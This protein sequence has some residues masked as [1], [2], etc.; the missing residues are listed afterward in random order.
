[1]DSE[2][3]INKEVI[4]L[5]ILE[6][7]AT[8]SILRVAIVLLVALFVAIKFPQGVTVACSMAEVLNIKVDTCEN[9]SMQETI[10]NP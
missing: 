5:K 4:L 1:M 6:N 9:G 2:V 3:I 10:H 7:V 8:K